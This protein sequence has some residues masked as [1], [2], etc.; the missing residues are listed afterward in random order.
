MVSLLIFTE[1]KLWFDLVSGPAGLN[2]MPR[3][4]SSVIDKKSSED[5]CIYITGQLYQASLLLSV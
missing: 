2:R 4:D 3:I 5:W 1:I